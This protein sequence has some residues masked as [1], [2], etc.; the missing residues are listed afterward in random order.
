[1]IPSIIEAIIMKLPTNSLISTL[2]VAVIAVDQQ[3]L[4]FFAVTAFH[5]EIKL[6]FKVTVYPCYT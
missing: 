1:M 4:D 2:Q 5:I 3:G 6:F